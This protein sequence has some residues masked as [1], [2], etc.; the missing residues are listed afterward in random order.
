MAEKKPLSP[1]KAR[2]NAPK[3]SDFDKY[4]I[5]REVKVVFKSTGQKDA[6]GHELGIADD[7]VIDKKIDIQE[8]L[9]SQADSVGVESYLRALS[10][11]GDSI[12]NYATQVGEEVDDFSEFP[13]TLADAMTLGDKSREAFEKMDPA[14][15]GNHTT[16]E[17]FLNSLS[18]ESIQAYIKGIVEASM[19]KK[20]GENI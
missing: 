3:F 13:D 6:E 14:L 1:F 15:K 8:Y 12:E 9:D 20:E 19:P 18:K 17:G 4:Y 10:L 11:Q 2:F 5:D 7:I 16:I